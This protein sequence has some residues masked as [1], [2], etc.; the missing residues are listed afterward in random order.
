MA[1]PLLEAPSRQTLDALPWRVIRF[2]MGVASS[3][4]ICRAL[5]AR[6]YGQQEHD[7]AFAR[8]QQIGAL[9]SIVR[10]GT[11]QN[12]SRAALSPNSTPGTNPTLKPSP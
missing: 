11:A 3:P 7:Y 1:M 4:D 8:L 12:R 2:L 6:G 10:Y 9:P 5:S